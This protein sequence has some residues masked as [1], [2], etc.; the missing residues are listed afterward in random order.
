VV[1]GDG[2]REPVA[3][4]DVEPN[5]IAV[6]EHTSVQLTVRAY[7]AKGREIVDP[8]VTFRCADPGVATIDADGLLRGVTPGQTTAAV[9]VADASASVIITVER[10]FTATLGVVPAPARSRRPFLIGVAAALVVV[11]GGAA[12]FATHKP[13]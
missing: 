8:V 2:P 6:T 11:T 13:K 12:L 10:A 1:R 4:V 9:S 3:R 5:V 7:T